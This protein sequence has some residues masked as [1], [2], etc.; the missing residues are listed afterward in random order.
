MTAQVE[1]ELSRVA[2]T[3]IDGGSSGNVTTLATSVLLTATE[4][5]RVMPFLYHNEGDTGLVAH[6]QHSASF[7][8]GTQFD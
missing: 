2:D 8:D 1:I 6:L 4:Q 5:P 7:T 3:D